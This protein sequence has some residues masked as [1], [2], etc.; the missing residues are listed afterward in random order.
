MWST[1]QQ[2]SQEL[3]KMK[4]SLGNKKLDKQEVDFLKSQ[5]EL[6]L[7]FKGKT[8]QLL[9]TDIKETNKKSFERDDKARE[10]L[11]SLRIKSD[12]FVDQLVTAGK[13]AYKDQQ[14]ISV[15]KNNLKLA[16]KNAPDEFSKQS[17]ILKILFEANAGK[18]YQKLTYALATKR[19]DTF[20]VQMVKDIHK[21]QSQY[22][23]AASTKWRSEADC[24]VGKKTI[25]E[26]CSKVWVAPNIAEV[27]VDAKFSQSNFAAKEKY[28]RANESQNQI[29]VIMKDAGISNVQ[30]AKSMVE[31]CKKTTTKASDGADKRYG[32][33]VYMINRIQTL[34]PTITEGERQA[35]IQELSVFSK[36]IAKYWNAGN[37]NKANQKSDDFLKDLNKWIE[38]KEKNEKRIDAVLSLCNAR[39]WYYQ[40]EAKWARSHGVAELSAQWIQQI[41]DLKNSTASPAYINTVL[42]QAFD[43]IF[44]TTE[45]YSIFNGFADEPERKEKLYGKYKLV[46]KRISNVVDYTEDHNK[47][48]DVLAEMKKLILSQDIDFS[49]PENITKFR[50]DFLDKVRHIDKDLDGG[51]FFDDYKS[52]ES[53]LGDIESQEKD[54]KLSTLVIDTKWVAVKDGFLEYSTFNTNIGK[55]NQVF[56][57]LDQKE[58]DPTTLKNMEEIMSLLN[59]SKKW[60]GYMTAWSMYSPGMYVEGELQI[61]QWAKSKFKELFWFDLPADQRKMLYKTLWE[62]MQHQEETKK[63]AITNF[64][65]NLQ[66]SNKELQ[67]DVRRYQSEIDYFKKSNPSD[68]RI[69]EYEADIGKMN[70]AIANN[71]NGIDG[72]AYNSAK[73]P[74]D[75]S[76]WIE[77]MTIQQQ[78]EAIAKNMSKYM[79]IKALEKTTTAAVIENNE[80]AIN[81][82]KNKTNKNAS[83][84]LID[85]YANIKGVGSYR[86]DETYNTV[87]EVTK[88]IIIQIAIC[89]VS[90]G[91]G[92]LVLKGAIAWTKRAL[93]ATEAA[94]WINMASKLWKYAEIAGKGL[95]GVWKSWKTLSTVER[96]GALTT[97]TVSMAIEWSAFHVSST[98]LNN[99]YQWNDI[100]TWLALN[101]KQNIRWYLQSIA[102][103]WVIKEVWGAFGNLTQKFMGNT[104]TQAELNTALGQT[105]KLSAGKKI[106]ISTASFATELASM[107]VSDQAISLAFDGKFKDMSVKDMTHMVGMILGLRLTHKFNPLNTL[108]QKLDEYIIKDVTK[109][110]DGSL[111]IMTFAVTRDGKQYETVLNSRWEIVRTTDPMLRKWVKAQVETYWARSSLWNKT[112]TSRS[113]VVEDIWKNRYTNG[114]ENI[115]EGIPTEVEIKSGEKVKIDPNGKH[116]DIIDQYKKLI[117]EKPTG[118]EQ[119]LDI[120]DIQLAEKVT[121]E[122][123]KAIEYTSDTEARESFDQLSKSPEYAWQLRMYKN[124]EGKWCVERLSANSIMPNIYISIKGMDGYRWAEYTWAIIKHGEIAIRNLQTGDQ[125]FTER[126]GKRYEFSKKANGNREVISASWRFTKGEEVKLMKNKDGAISFERVS[127][128]LKMEVKELWLK[129]FSWSNE[130][131]KD[132]IDTKKIEQL[133]EKFDAKIMS[134][135]G[136]DIDGKNYKLVYEQTTPN[137]EGGE[138]KILVDGKVILDKAKSDT[139]IL[140]DTKEGKRIKER[141]YALRERYVS[142]E[143]DDTNK[144]PVKPDK[145]KVDPAKDEEEIVK[146]EN[147]EPI[148]I[149]D[150]IDIDN[151]EAPQ[152]ISKLEK[153]LQA[154]ESDASVPKS[155][156]RESF[157]L[158]GKK[159]I[160]DIKNRKL[161]DSMNKTLIRDGDTLVSR[162]W[163]KFEISI[164]EKGKAYLVNRNKITERVEFTDT[165]LDNYKV[166]KRAT[167]TGKKGLWYLGT[168]SL[169]FLQKRRVVWLAIK[170]PRKFI[171]SVNTIAAEAKS[172]YGPSEGFNDVKI[173]KY[174]FIFRE[175]TLGNNPEN[176]LVFR[177]KQLLSKWIKSVLNLWASPNAEFSYYNRRS[178]KGINRTGV[179]ENDLVVGQDGKEY[180]ARIAWWKVLLEW[181]TSETIGTSINLM[182]DKLNEYRVVK[183]E[184]K[185]NL[186]YINGRIQ[187]FSAN[188]IPFSNLAIFGERDIGRGGNRALRKIGLKNNKFEE[189]TNNGKE[190]EKQRR[191]K[192]TRVSKSETFSDL[193]KNVDKIW[194]INIASWEKL[195]AKTLKKLI[196]NVKNGTE[197]LWTLPTELWIRVKVEKLIIRNQ[198]FSKKISSAKTIDEIYAIIKGQS[199]IEWSNKIYT[200]QELINIIKWVR[201]GAKPDNG[202]TRSFGI[203]E[204]VN[205]L[206]NEERLDASM[207]SLWPEWLMADVEQWYVGNCYFVACLYK[208]KT[209]PRWAEL[210]S[211][212]IKP[213]V[214]DVPLRWKTAKET[215]WEVSFYN[216][217]GT[218]W[219]RVIK[220][221]DINQGFQ[222]KSWQLWDHIL[223]RA[224][225]KYVN[226]LKWGISWQTMI[227][228]PEWKFKFEGWR[229]EQT[230]QQFFWPLLKDNISIDIWF[231]AG[232]GGINQHEMIEYLSNMSDQTL[233]TFW[234]FSKWYVGLE[235]WRKIY[236]GKPDE[237]IIKILDKQ[238]G[239]TDQ[240]FVKDI[241]WNLQK[242]YFWHAYAT[243]E[244][245][246]KE[247]WVEMV[248][249]HSTKDKRFKVYFKDVYEAFDDFTKTEFIEWQSKTGRNNTETAKANANLQD[250]PR[251]QTAETLLSLTPWSLI[252]ASGKFTAKG[253]AILDAH[254]QPGVVDQLTLGQ[255]RSRMEILKNAGFTIPQIKVLMDNYICGKNARDIII[256]FIEPIQ[257]ALASGNLDKVLLLGQKIAPS[258]IF[259]TSEIPV[260]AIDGVYSFV[261]TYC[262]GKF[263]FDISDGVAFVWKLKM[264]KDA[265]LDAVM[266]YTEHLK[267]KNNFQEVQNNARLSWEPRI[268]KWWEITENIGSLHLSEAQKEIMKKTILKAHAYG[269]DQAGKDGNSASIYNYTI[270]QLGIKMYTLM[271]GMKECNIDY[272][273]SRKIAKELLK[274]GICGEVEESPVK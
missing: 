123:N 93:E 163:E 182:E 198:L 197:N 200:A 74:N 40:K 185:R 167:E 127:D 110:I 164:D 156:N 225:D 205:E 78:A 230:F 26:L 100:A 173:N 267:E 214:V 136:I 152:N 120:L 85:L 99:A 268:Q 36:E 177:K 154:V 24:I 206:V 125:I 89:A 195:D 237:E 151:I 247:W 94:R 19:T 240:Y 253:K 28:N 158:R 122:R 117:I 260:T 252:D 143:L 96:V 204:R 88:E 215:Q 257:N 194:E 148:K 263:G 262:R 53:I 236:P 57:K 16:L 92:S 149:E 4:N 258:D 62:I 37:S 134:N 233:L 13:L 17:I 70:W 27:Q 14:N 135:E 239:D 43:K 207:K 193:Y 157:V 104:M 66:R 180:V 248:N 221:S 131:M 178:C 91:V 175:E 49:K 216:K 63:N 229:M 87:I 176:L 50:S 124:F 106:L 116:K 97:W 31:V 162:R 202:I 29:D 231:G 201:E 147:S 39:L 255:I 30:K 217:D 172:F 145:I 254:N 139:R 48:I 44:F 234:S 47:Q 111:E 266:L 211:K 168:R 209:H 246:T 187:D 191:Q 159:E 18:V 55:V 107:E 203:R 113:R 35:I 259:V 5:K 81:K 184:W 69:K 250:K 238:N 42:S 54:Q 146:D 223:E 232:R 10:L 181:I 59:S 208:L 82:L 270:H 64:K 226:E 183:R 129:Q 269:H 212:M 210:I 140:P 7:S 132:I 249:P 222:L 2:Q 188:N 112:P 102:F 220:S 251:L 153:I 11:K 174:N 83:E 213:I 227:R 86:S 244:I 38:Q 114:N 60:E 141:Y 68:H 144:N 137:Q 130:A 224:Y 72:K 170:Y 1:E 166:V 121:L 3:E 218:R 95:I 76:Q 142:K 241:T 20:D 41:R 67:E 271:D 65:N 133:V 73:N 84:K 45:A 25:Q 138:W 61:N 235:Q 9:L 256:K 8:E 169:D 245:N 71:Q 108:N 160:F 264:V 243:G 186:R 155:I 80:A 192:E 179:R 150:L 161:L 242:V 109:W 219:S 32:A 199:L 103:L 6:L 272:A 101:S 22:A 51:S 265:G 34:L 23:S 261:D 165:M 274:K 79:F 126:G 189:S 273:T 15:Y 128:W 46:N 196:E 33:V 56:A 119:A 75:P 21:F 190:E 171:K 115:N 52:W 77:S 118:Y 12:S 90:A 105:V 228:G 58:P 98:L